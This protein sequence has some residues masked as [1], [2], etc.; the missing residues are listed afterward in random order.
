MNL[1]KFA[2]M[3]G[4]FGAALA[5]VLVFGVSRPKPVSREYLATHVFLVRVGKA[6]E[7]Y[8]SQYG[9]FPTGDSRAV[10]KILLGVPSD[11]NPQGNVFLI[12]AN[13]DEKARLNR[14]GDLVD[15]WGRPIAFRFDN[16][17][18]RVLS[19]GKNHKD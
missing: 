2:T 9:K 19:F 10:G 16:S 18:Y 17:S 8:Y 4:L 11:Q 3:V 14:D 1:K 13:G 5:G 15:S 6:L 12:L 7:Q